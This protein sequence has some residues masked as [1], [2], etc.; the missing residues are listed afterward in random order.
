MG[1]RG[2]RD[3]SV[4]I[5]QDVDL[6]AGLFDDDERASFELLPGRKSPKAK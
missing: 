3:G 5:H 6:F 1:S 2:E 4:V